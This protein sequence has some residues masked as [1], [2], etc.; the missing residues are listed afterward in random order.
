M[1]HDDAIENLKADDVWINIL[2]MNYNS[3]MHR[4]IMITEMDARIITQIVIHCISDLR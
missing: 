3:Q 1:I 4:K 2:F